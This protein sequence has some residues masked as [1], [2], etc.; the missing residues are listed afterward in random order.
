M[1]ITIYRYRN[2]LNNKSYVGQTKV[3][4]QR[5]SQHMSSAFNE[6]ANDY[7]SQ[8][9]MAVRKYGKEG[10]EYIVLEVCDESQYKEREIYWI[11]HYNSFKEGYNATAGGDSGV[12]QKYG[13]NPRA[14][15]SMDD[16]IDI[17]TRYGNLEPFRFV[18]EDY[19]DKITKRGLQKVW[20]YE[21]WKGIMTEVYTDENKVWHN[22]RAKALSPFEVHNSVF[23]EL[24]IKT[25]YNHRE[26]N[27]SISK[28]Y[29]EKYA[30]RCSFG[31]LEQVWYGKTYL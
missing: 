31:T 16:V 5:H 19:K 9:H 22:T 11:S 4:V 6:I 27:D 23:S 14:L 24:D 29:K 28:V 7:K 20:Y 17:R 13:A 8:F 1:K 26:A 3:P 12:S 15:L 21:T 25:I 10:F 2:K 30:D 18:Y